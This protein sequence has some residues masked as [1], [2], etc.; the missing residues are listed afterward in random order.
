MLWYELREMFVSCA[1]YGTGLGNY[2][3][4]RC[5]WCWPDGMSRGLMLYMYCWIGHA[6]DGA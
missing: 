5:E 1:M 2:T 3:V 6:A 4:H